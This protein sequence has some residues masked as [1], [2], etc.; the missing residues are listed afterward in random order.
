MLAPICI[1]PGFSLLSVAAFWLSE[2][3]QSGL[4]L[5]GLSAMA[6][7]LVLLWRA[8]QA[9]R[10]RRYCARLIIV[11]GSNVVHW[12]AVVGTGAGGFDGLAGAGPKRFAFDLNQIEGKPTH[13]RHSVCCVLR[14]I[15]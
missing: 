15:R 4:L 13:S 14:L 3:W 10:T 2:P 8:W 1:L 7:S 6:S 12:A 5:L 11:D 9:A